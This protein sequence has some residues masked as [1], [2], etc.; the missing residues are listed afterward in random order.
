MMKLLY[1]YIFSLIVINSTLFCQTEVGAKRWQNDLKSQKEFIENKNQFDDQTKEDRK[2]LFGAQLGD[3]H[4]FLSTN[5]LIYRLDAIKKK[6]G[7][8]PLNQGEKQ[9][10]HQK[11]KNHQ[12]QSTFLEIKWLKSNPWV[13]ISTENIVPNYYTYPA[14]GGSSTCPGLIARAYKKVIYKNLYANIDVEYFFPEGKE[15]LKYNIIL[16][17]G[18]NPQDIQM[19]YQGDETLL[20]LSEQGQL[21]FSLG[22]SMFTE[23]QPVSF[24][25]NNRLIQTQFVL[26]GNIVQ[27]SLASFD[28]TKTIVID[29]WVVNPLFTEINDALVI[30]RDNNGNI[31]LLGGDDIDL[32]QSNPTSLKKY[33]SVGILLWEYSIPSPLGAHLEGQ[34]RPDFTVNQTTGEVYLISNLMLPPTIKKIATTGIEIA[35]YQFLD[36]DTLKKPEFWRIEYDHCTNTLLVGLGNIVS[37]EY[38]FSRVNI[39]RLNDDF[40]APVFFSMM[41]KRAD[42][43][44]LHLNKKNQ[45]IVST[46]CNTVSNVKN[47]LFATNTSTLSSPFIDTSTLFILWEQYYTNQSIHQVG[48]ASTDQFIYIFSGHRLEKRDIQTGALLLDVITETLTA[49]YAN[50]TWGGI[51]VDDCGNIY[52]GVK[53]KVLKYD[54]NFNLLTTF[55]MPEEVYDLV[56]GNRNNLIVCGSNFMTEVDLLPS[57]FILD[58]T[59]ITSCNA[60]D[61]TATL[62]SF[63]SV[64][65]NEYTYSWNTSPEQSTPNASNLCPGTYTLTIRSKNCNPAIVFQDSVIISAEPGVFIIQSL[66]SEASECLTETGTATVTVS[67]GVPPFSLNWNTSPSQT[68]ETATG[69]SPGI[70]TITAIDSEGCVLSRSI[71]VLS[72]NTIVTNLTATE[73]TCDNFSEITAAISGGTPPYSIAWNN[74]LS[75]S[76]ITVNTPGTYSAIVTDSIACT[77]HDTITVLPPIFEPS[78]SMYYNDSLCTGQALL[79][80]VDNDSLHTLTYSWA[81]P[82]D[83]SSTVQNPVIPDASSE[84][85]GMYLLLVNDGNCTNS[86]SIWV[87]IQNQPIAQFW[88]DTITGCNPLMVTFWDQSDPGSEFLLWDFGD[89]TTSSQLNSVTHT[90]YGSDNYDISLLTISNGCPAQLEKLAYISVYDKAQAKFSVQPQTTTTDHPFF[91]FTNFSSNASSFVWSFGDSSSSMNQHTDHWYTE[92]A[93]EL[94]VQLIA[95]NEGNCPDTSILRINIIEPLLF[96][97]P[98]AFTPDGNDYNQEFKPVFTSGFEPNTYSITIYDRWGEKIFASQETEKG[99]GGTYRNEKLQDG[100][101][102][103]DIYFKDKFT[104]KMYHYTG[105]VNLLR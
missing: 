45:K 58:P 57:M 94:E 31:Y 63:C 87:V 91:S 62:S 102:T 39:L 4:V 18:A 30:N 89:G 72:L 61:G 29:P 101:Y 84:N 85:E 20:S 67:G 81:G 19:E 47:F 70:W 75:S 82:N 77:S 15:G 48:I 83:F 76:S 12:F 6:E 103:W 36:P 43:T 49:Y 14:K 68:T 55:P 38:E 23:H 78:L 104:D 41:N 69:L 52:V 93:R 42:L 88:A 35:T 98:N 90:F 74:N 13:E 54:S 73:F 10:Q 71:E 8:P 32:L 25:Q 64:D 92:E 27:F 37:N 66:T 5:S 17:P 95:N 11:L 60:C 96:Y 79:L 80:S 59:D 2:I 26:K 97:I 3:I 99:W 40:S 16:H 7:N 24:D 28:A 46:H 86:D 100:I 44:C 1:C 22:N 21:H 65:F 53:N 9:G 51:D 105:H 56:L 50:S 34:I 33:N